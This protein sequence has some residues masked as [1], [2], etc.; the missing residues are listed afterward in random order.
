MIGIIFSRDRALQLDATLR[1]FSLHCQDPEH[2]QLNVLYL[3]SSPL[4]ARQYI[5]LSK[6][7]HRSLS[8]RFIPQIQFRSDLLKILLPAEDHKFWQ[9]IRPQ[10]IKM[11]PRFGFLNRFGLAN[12]SWD[13]VFFIVDD[14]LFIRDFRLRG[15]E[16][17]TYA[18]P[19]AIG[20]SLRLGLNT[21]YCYTKH[22]HQS[23]PSFIHVEQDIL[24]FNWTSGELDFGYPLEI[25]SS[26]YSSK[27][28]WDLLNRVPFR[29]PNTLENRMASSKRFYQ[30]T[31]PHLLCFEQSVTFC[32]PINKVQTVWDNR[33]G[34][35]PEYSVEKLADL[36]SKGYRIQVESFSDFT[37]NG[38]HQEVEF[39]LRRRNGG[40]EG[41]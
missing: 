12:T 3:A 30:F 18:N 41:W 8:I 13:Y 11:G 20:F 19:D 7:Y 9:N 2:I 36:F 40:I 33:S 15:I 23:L 27:L 35:D 38:C 37:P 31:H 1:S 22:S 24:K 39:T 28:L 14:N 10:A 17:A 32:N 29:N 6:E 5:E 4:H 16:Q 21:T 26:I 34:S 25:S